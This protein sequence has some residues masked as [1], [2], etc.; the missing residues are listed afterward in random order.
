MRAL[1]GVG[2]DVF[3]RYAKILAA[4]LPS[5]VSDPKFDRPY[6]F[7]SPDGKPVA[8]TPVVHGI[9]ESKIAEMLSSGTISKEQASAS[10]KAIRA[11]EAFLSSFRATVQRNAADLQNLKREASPKK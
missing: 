3:V 5:Q 10:V 7:V 11:K 4:A 8:M 9:S 1:G 2:E 6:R